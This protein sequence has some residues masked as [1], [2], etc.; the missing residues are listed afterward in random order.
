[1]VSEHG[2]WFSHNSSH[3]G[4]ALVKPQRHGVIP[5]P[6]A[7][8]RVAIAATA[9]TIATAS[10]AAVAAV[11]TVT[12]TQTYGPTPLSYD[13]LFTP[14]ENATDLVS[15]S[16]GS[17]YTGE[18]ANLTIQAIAS[19]DTTVDVFTTVGGTDLQPWFDTV[20]LSSLTNNSFTDFSPLEIKGLR[21]TLTN[22]SGGPEPSLTLDTG[23]QFVFAVVPEPAAGV[24]LA[25]GLVAVF[26]GRRVRRSRSTPPAS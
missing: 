21:F 17:V 24:L 20:P 18:A 4:D 12:T 10:G 1:M 25:C 9:G 15:I 7:E 6:C 16:D 3:F 19:D 13:V 11:T 26:V 22:D 8:K 5:G 14:I 2:R 23:T